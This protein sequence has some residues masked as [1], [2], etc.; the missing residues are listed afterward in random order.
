MARRSE[1]RGTGTERLRDI[2][3]G[4][5]PREEPGD[6]STPRR[7]VAVGSTPRD[8]TTPSG[9][10]PHTQHGAAMARSVGSTPRTNSEAS[11][12]HTPD[13]SE[14]GPK[15]P[16]SMPRRERHTNASP[17]DLFPTIKPALTDVESAAAA[18]RAR[19]R[20]EAT[21][22]RLYQ[23]SRASTQSI[24]ETGAQGGDRR[25]RGSI[26]RN[27]AE[28]RSERA[29]AQ[30]GGRERR[31]N[32]RFEPGKEAASHNA[33]L[34]QGF[35]YDLGRLIQAHASTTLGFGSEFRTVPELRP[36]LGGHSHFEKLA[37][38][39]TNGMEYVFTRELSETERKD[40][41]GAMLARG[42]HKSAQSEQDQVGKLI[43]KDVLHGF[44]IPIPVETVVLIPGAMVQP[45]GLVQ[46]WTVAP[47]GERVIKYR[48]TQDLSFSTDKKA[49]TVSINS[50]VDMASYPEMIYGWCLPRIIHYIVSLRIHSPTL[51]IL[52]SKYDYSDA[53]RRMAHSAKAATQTVSVNGDTAFVSLRLTFGG[54]PNP[55]TWCM[56]SEL[57]TDL[58]NEIAQC[59]EW[60]PE[61]LKPRPTADT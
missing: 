59:G 20:R 10:A 3:S 27:Q 45:L 41:V 8:A 2:N 29:A 49:P 25:R 28:Y 37:E 1:R 36:L 60:D 47:D 5:I 44:T 9:S 34:L 61:E 30:G 48:L 14:P 13:N 12:A 57:V 55:P 11:M 21:G 23:R 32:L 52:I 18:R 4:S 38:L 31:V 40:E 46:Q 43:S 35:G 54:S 17:R 53:Y 33:K 42:N 16:S 58:A 51:L 39:L 56:F 15:Y 24:L 26:E 19:L 6:G 7:T 22:G 50:R